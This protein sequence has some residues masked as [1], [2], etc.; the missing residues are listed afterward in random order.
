MFH[1]HHHRQQQLKVNCEYSKFVLVLAKFKILTTTRKK[2]QTIVRAPRIV[3]FSSSPSLHCCLTT[4]KKSCG[5][6]MSCL[7]VCAWINSTPCCDPLEYHDDSIAIYS[8][9][10]F[11]FSSS[12][13][14]CTSISRLCITRCF[15][16][17]DPMAT[18]PSIPISLKSRGHTLFDRQAQLHA[19]DAEKTSNAILDIPLPSTHMISA[20]SVSS[21]P[22]LVQHHQSY[23]PLLGQRRSPVAVS[24]HRQSFS[25]QGNVQLISVHP[26]QES[27]YIREV[28]LPVKAAEQLYET[29]FPLVENSTIDKTE[30]SAA[31]SIPS[32]SLCCAMIEQAFDYLHANDD[33]DD[34]PIEPKDTRENDDDQPYDGDD[35][36]NGDNSDE[37]DSVDTIDPDTATRTH[38]RHDSK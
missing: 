38:H 19:D 5:R 1:H 34:Q 21:I 18:P 29:D 13:F 31:N 2:S 7:F 27:T 9:L 17:L 16:R 23:S 15:S 30:P 28:P 12:E 35:F 36:D 26:R 11:C 24:G 8:F 10:L 33:D 22:S 4:L 25:E 20:R 14:V 32:D 37:G 6:T 3:F